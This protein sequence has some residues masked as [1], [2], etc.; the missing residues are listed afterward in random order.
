MAEAELAQQRVTAGYVT[1]VI[2][3]QVLA[4]VIL[5]LGL[6]A[7]LTP[8]EGPPSWSTVATWLGVPLVLL[9]WTATRARSVI[10][11]IMIGLEMGLMIYATW[12]LALGGW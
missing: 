4:W 2:G 12:R 9:A 10:G 1:A 7:P 6:V 11:R 3:T 5:G 8:S